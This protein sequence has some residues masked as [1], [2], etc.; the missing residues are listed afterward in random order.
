MCQDHG[1]DMDKYFL[2]GFGA[3]E[4]T[5]D[6]IG[7]DKHLSCRAIAIDKS[8]YGQTYDEIEKTLKAG[9][10]KV[11]GKQF[12]FTVKYIDLAKYIKRFDFMVTSELSKS[13]SE[14]ELPEQEQQRVFK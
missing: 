1:V 10:G 5:I 9:D 14:I 6:G 8:I 7:Q 11:Q 4:S 12:N 13:I 2:I 3:G